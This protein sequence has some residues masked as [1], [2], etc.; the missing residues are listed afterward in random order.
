MR[1]QHTAMRRLKQ[2]HRKA[3]SATAG[4]VIRR[5]QNRLIFDVSRELVVEIE[6]LT[7]ELKRGRP[8]L[9]FREEP[10]D[11]TGIGIRKRNQRFLYATT[12]SS[13]RSRR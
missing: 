7:V 9:A 5:C 12:K 2:G 3:D 6:F 4:R 10:L 13:N 8:H 1:A 11:L